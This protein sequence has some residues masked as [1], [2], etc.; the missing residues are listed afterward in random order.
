MKRA[1]GL[2]FNTIVVAAIALLI[3]AVVV[4][5]LMG[6]LGGW[7][8]NVDKCSAKNGQCYTSCSGSMLP[9]ANT[10]CDKSNQICCVP[11]GSG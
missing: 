11:F 6:K 5:I 2:S 4:L 3:L 1:Q 7:S 10:D 8:D 9:V